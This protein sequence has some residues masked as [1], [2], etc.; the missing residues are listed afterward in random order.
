MEEIASGKIKHRAPVGLARARGAHPA[1]SHRGDRGLQGLHARAP[2]RAR[3]PRGRSARDARARSGSSRPRRSSRWRA[4]RRD[5]DPYPHLGA[6]RLLVVA[7]LTANTLAR[8]AHGLADD[9]LTEAALAH[10]GPGARRAGDEHAHVGAPGDAGER[11]DAARARRRARRAGG[12][13]AR[14]GRGRRRAAWPSPRRSPRGSR[15]CSRAS[16]EPARCAGRRVLV[17]AGGTREP[18]DSVRYVGNRSSGRMGVALA[19]E[20]QAARRRRDAARR[21]PRRPGP[22]GVDGR[23]DAD[24]R[25]P[26]ARGAGAR[27]RRRRRDGRG[28]RRLP[29]CRAARRAKRPKDGG[30]L[31]GR[32]R[33]DDRR[34]RRARRAGARRRR[35]SSASPPRRARTASSARARSG[36]AK[37]ADLVVFNDVSRADIGFDALENEVVLVSA[38]GEHAVAKAPKPVVAAADPRRG[39]AA[40]LV[41]HERRRARGRGGRDRGPAAE[42]VERV[43]ENLEQRSVHRA[44]RSSSASSASSPRGT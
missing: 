2:A 44:R 14:G 23:R 8:L 10:V 9:V 17:S 11:R 20:A 7:P 42:V 12:G 38:D 31:D 24:R 16:H 6:P 19:E 39:G 32:A 41:Q 29:C 26:R 25:R 22:A 40:T 30:D 1:R 43:V 3:R 37:N 21:E 13:R 4:S 33:A 34:P 27:G 35:S 18:L 15:R 28:R 5:G 36:E